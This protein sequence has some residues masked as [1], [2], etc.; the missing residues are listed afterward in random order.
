[1]SWF[2]RLLPN[3]TYAIMRTI[4]KKLNCNNHIQQLNIAPMEE[5]WFYERLFFEVVI[6]IGKDKKQS[7]KDTKSTKMSFMVYVRIVS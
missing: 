4:Q 6:V 5:T 7:I 1:M 2:Q 3:I